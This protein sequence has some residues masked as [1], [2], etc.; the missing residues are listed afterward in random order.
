M[1]ARELLRPNGR[2]IVRVPNAACWQSLLLAESWSGFDVPRN[3]VHFRA[4]DI[5]ALLEACG[6]EVVRRNFFSLQDNPV[7]FVTSLAPWLD[8]VVR[9]ARGKKEFAPIK[10]GLDL[11]YYALVSAAVPFALVEAACR[12]GSSVT[13]EARKKA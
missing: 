6:F 12:A 13:F 5:Q 8:P 11:V 1:A 7:A 10:L 3:I 2:L 9:R 4:V